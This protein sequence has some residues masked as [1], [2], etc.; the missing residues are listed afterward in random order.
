MAEERTREFE[1]TADD[2]AFVRRYL[3]MHAGINLSEQKRSM[4][5]SRLARRLR[6][7]GMMRFS[8]YRSLLESGDVVEMSA[9]VNA[10]TTNLTMFFRENHHFQHLNDALLP[11][12]AAAQARRL[13]L[14]SA[15]CSTGEEPYSIAIVLERWL[16]GKP[17]VDAKILATDLDTNVLERARAGVYAEKT[18]QPVAAWS[19]TALDEERGGQWRVT[20][21]LR[22]LITFKKLNLL[23]KWPVNG[24]FDAIFCRNVMI[25]FDRPTQRD[26]V[27]RFH[28]LLAPHGVL[29]LGH[30]ESLHY[31][32]GLFT[33]SGRT[34]YRKA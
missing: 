14:W 17:G 23:H 16:R 26:L 12:R 18:I 34:I 13:R 10:L 22:R 9:C 2:F 8:E 32:T 15:G 1:F 31:L 24:P 6:A 7:L 21:G 25:Y 19:K 30:S 5:Y 11:D 33:A 28:A 3:K 20:P 27:E 4:V 29:Y